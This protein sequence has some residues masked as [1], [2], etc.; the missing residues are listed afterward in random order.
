MYGRCLSLPARVN[1]QGCLESHEG[2]CLPHSD[3][4]NDSY[5]QSI[6]IH[7]LAPLGGWVPL[8]NL[9]GDP[10]TICSCMGVPYHIIAGAMMCCK[11]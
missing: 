7:K 6:H 2:F 9:P 3:L 8:M 5:T 10:H 1:V 11:A 4:E